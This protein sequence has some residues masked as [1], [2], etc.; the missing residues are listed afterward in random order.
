[1]ES[2][3]HRTQASQLADDLSWLE[4]HARQQP[5]LTAQTAQLR[6][7]AGLVRNVVGPYLDGQAPSPLHLS[8][9]GGAGTGK[10]TIVNFL[11]GRVIAEA[12]P[13]AGFTRHP[14]AYIA[15]TTPGDRGELAWTSH[16]GFLGPLQRLLDP[17]PAD[18]DQDVY[19]VRRVSPVSEGDSLGLLKDFVI[20]DCP[21]MTTWAATGYIPRLL[22][23]SSLSDVIVYVA[24]DERYNDVIPTQYLQM[25][26]QTGK[27]V[28]VVLTKMRE[29]DAVPLANHF[30]REVIDKLPKTSEGKTPVVPVLTI[31][32]LTPEQLSDP[33]KSAG[34]YRIPLINQIGVLSNPVKAGRDRTVRNAMAFLSHE[35]NTLLSTAKTDLQVLD[36][37]HG[38]VMTGQAEF[39]HRYRR[40]YLSGEP[41]R[42]FEDTRLE[43]LDML[44]LPSAGRI[45]TLVFWALRA[46]YRMLRGLFQHVVGRPSGVNLPE[47]D[48]LKGGL[49]A[50][51]D[52]LRSEALQ[53][54][55]T[56]PLWKHIGLGFG[57]G[58]D[59]QARQQFE[60]HYRMFQLSV[61]DE[62]EGARRNITESLRKNGG[63][64]FMMRIGKLTLD[65]VAIGVAFWICGLTLWLILAI[66]VLVSLAHQVIEIFCRAYVDVAREKVRQKQEALVSEHLAKPVGEWLNQWPVSGGSTFERLQRSLRR[67]PE[68]IAQLTELVRKRMNGNGD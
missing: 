24:S 55:A 17:T 58:M 6:L 8:V 27:P 46:P 43:L 21:D 53:R 36:A 48:V 5:E 28:I 66:P 3:D 14:I 38:L 9:V 59:Q 18:L 19:Q 33:V 63:L 64:L 37:W 45:L 23:V 1:M 47:H 10:S 20:W 42:R 32:F 56:H 68:T 13:Q 62:V 67:V 34:K 25:L 11:T 40:E 65:L 16:L 41:F 52:Q 15:R 51:L 22:E 26:V 12:N 57:S 30:Q 39:N 4:Q 50:W 2:F 60:S 35:A 61:A 31:P 49:D 54:S 44:E 29:A 7:A